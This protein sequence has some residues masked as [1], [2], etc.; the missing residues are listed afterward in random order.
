MSTR[1]APSTSPAKVTVEFVMISRRTFRFADR[2]ARRSRWRAQSGD[3]RSFP[4]ST[5]SWAPLRATSASSI[6][7]ISSGQIRNSLRSCSAFTSGG[8]P[9]TA[10]ATFSNFIRGTGRSAI[11]VRPFTARSSP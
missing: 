11:V 8:E 2:P 1:A 6:R 5:R 10:S 7:P 3:H 9:G 4:S